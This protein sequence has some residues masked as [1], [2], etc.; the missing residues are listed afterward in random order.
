MALF[1]ALL[2]WFMQNRK[3]SLHTFLARTPQAERV[4]QSST[5]TSAVRRARGRFP[6]RKRA[7]QASAPVPAPAPVPQA[8]QSAP[9]TSAVRRA[10]GRFPRQRAEQEPAPQYE[11][12]K[13]KETPPLLKEKE[14]GSGFCFTCESVSANEQNIEDIKETTSVL[15]AE[16][17]K[18][19]LKKRILGR[20]Q[21]KILS[22]SILRACITKDKNWFEENDIKW[23]VAQST[24]AYTKNNIKSLIKVWYPEMRVNLALGY[25]KPKA[26]WL[27][28][29]AQSDITKKDLFLI[30]LAEPASWL[31]AHPTHPVTSLGFMPKLSAE[32][33]A[34]AQDRYIETLTSLPLEGSA[35]AKLKKMLSQN[36][37]G[38]FSAQELEE[39]EE[40]STQVDIKARYIRT[41]L[42]KVEEESATFTN[43]SGN[44]EALSLSDSDE[45]KLSSKDK[46]LL[47][48]AAQKLRQESRDRYFGIMGRLPILSYLKTNAPNDPDLDKAY[49]K[50]Q[51]TLEDFLKKI[52]DPDVDMSLLLS[53]EPL[54]EQLLNEH[55]HYCS[56][57]EQKRRQVEQDKETTNALLISAGVALAIPCFFT[58]VAGASLCLAGGAS[59]GA[60]S[61]NYSKESMRSSLGKTF[62]GADL[63]SIADL[64]EKD[65]DLLLKTMFLPLAFW[66]TTATPAK[67][68]SKAVANFVNE[69][70]RG[71]GNVSFF[72]NTERV[73]GG[74][75]TQRILSD[76]DDQKIY[77]ER[78]LGRELNAQE[79]NSLERA[80]LVGVGQRGEDGSVAR[81][82][83][84]TFTQIR[85]KSAIL[86]NAGFT[87]RERRK[88]IEE[89]IVGLNYADI[90]HKLKTGDNILGESV[91]VH[92]EDGPLMG[93]IV[94]KISENSVLL[95]TLET[96]GQVA[97]IKRWKL[98]LRR[99]KVKLSADDM[100]HVDKFEIEIIEE[101]E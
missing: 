76:S 31:N 19:Q 4:E 89:G 21:S 22:I 14:Q 65:K 78:I 24:C 82:G 84:Y 23:N 43:L 95:E 41:V 94:Q 91:I 59:L 32:E 15:Y 8:E 35:G 56:V 77:A 11:S 88:L 64:Y 79:M 54:V 66:G 3:T 75:V 2:F 17:F 55:P 39:T 74:S 52:K 25:P 38:Q 97:K 58:G 9:A 16:G 45:V 18:E 67:F 7:E 1:T 28:A 53:F 37:E 90:A 50:M 98:S 26:Q 87:R 85:E 29:R 57:A 5:A 69:R 47:R 33:Q 34:Q 70:A 48:E 40:E 42:D 81:A 60:F 20:I 51:S 100:A 6:T 49:S 36:A 96:S 71:A 62:T 13:G 86:S 99:T 63:E 61:Y 73:G 72:V 80:H 93:A 30:S 83:N 68:V 92:S 46:T 44:E 101:N 12:C 10:R 27:G